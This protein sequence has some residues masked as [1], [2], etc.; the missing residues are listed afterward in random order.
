MSGKIDIFLSRVS[1]ISQFVLVAF[2]IFGYFYT[3]RPIYQKEL[4][5]EDIAKKEIELN[6]LRNKLRESE[7]HLSN[8]LDKQLKLEFNISKLNDQ[9]VKAESQLTSITEK[10]NQAENNLTKQKLITKDTLEMNAQNLEDLYWENLSALV[11]S[12][13]VSHAAWLANNTTYDNKL[14]YKDYRKLYITPYDAINKAL[15]ENANLISSAKNIPDSLRN[16]I[17]KKVRQKLNENKSFLNIYPDGFYN[18]VSSAEMKLQGYE[19]S[20]D[21]ADVM[22]SHEEER[23]IS[24]YIYAKNKESQTIAVDFI[25]KLKKQ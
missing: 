11:T 7:I 24:N 13:Y 18:R 16:D 4:L 5:S 6:L 25:N 1:H 19:Q 8:N 23:S 10:L 12:N 22:N 3:V 20:N 15:D 2:A 14:V 21:M 9:Y 17:N